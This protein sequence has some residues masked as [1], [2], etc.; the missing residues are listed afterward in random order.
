MDTKLETFYNIWHKESNKMK[1]KVQE[2][3]Q[4]LIAYHMRKKLKR[5]RKK[6]LKKATQ[7][8]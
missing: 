7:K 3:A 8:Q 4:I 1:D 2:D 6:K 5:I